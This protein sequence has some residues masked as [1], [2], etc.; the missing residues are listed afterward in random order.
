MLFDCTWKACS[1]LGET[2]QGCRLERSRN[3]GRSARKTE[4]E[5]MMA[6]VWKPH[7]CHGGSHIHRT[8]FGEGSSAS[9]EG[10]RLWVQRWALKQSAGAAMPLTVGL[11]LAHREGCVTLSRRW[12]A[13]EPWWKMHLLAF[14]LPSNVPPCSCACR[15]QGGSAQGHQSSWARGGC[16]TVTPDKRPEARQE[17]LLIGD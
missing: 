4:L 3:L 13:L 16:G 1:V 2:H 10:T 8:W 15:W 11:H 12:R 7:V 6:Q 17:T 14:S 9:T 5:G